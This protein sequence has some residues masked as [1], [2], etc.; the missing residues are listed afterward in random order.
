MI[1]ELTSA[2][3]EYCRDWEEGNCPI[4]NK[5][6][7]TVQEALKHIFEHLAELQQAG[8]GGDND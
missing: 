3:V 7:W 5:H 6:L 2:D 8:E 4:C 1:V